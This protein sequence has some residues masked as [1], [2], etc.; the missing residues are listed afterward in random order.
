MEPIV[1]IIDSG[2]SAKLIG[3]RLIDAVSF[4]QGYPGNDDSGHGTA[5]AAVIKSISPDTRFVSLS[6]LDACGYTNSSILR[7][8][9]EYCLSIDCHIINLSLSLLDE[10]NSD[11]KNICDKLQ[12][13]GKAVF[14]AVRNRCAASEPAVFDSVIG[15]R[16]GL[17]SSPNEF[18]FNEHESI[19]LITDMT[20]VFTSPELGKY[21]IFSGNSKATA[22]GSGLAAK[23]IMLQDAADIQ[24]TYSNFSLRCT[25]SKWTEQE[26]QGSLFPHRNKKRSVSIDESDLVY[27]K[28]ARLIDDTCKPVAGRTKDK[29][30]HADDNLFEMGVIAS[31][32]IVPLLQGL[33][34]EFKIRLDLKTITPLMLESVNCIYDMLRGVKNK[35]DKNDNARMEVYKGST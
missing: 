27:K 33:E 34:K 20:P 31:D 12:K 16:G 23:S 6:I 5:C 26:L 8:A 28:I 11:I 13:Q 1:V 4:R 7:K 10:G 18:W 9:L 15:V 19:Q 2:I 30:L 14:A 21:F 35:A 25:K 32:T 29:P 22:V 24:K 17:F 3:D